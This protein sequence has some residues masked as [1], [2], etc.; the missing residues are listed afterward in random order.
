MYRNILFLKINTDY[1]ASQQKKSILNLALMDRAEKLKSFIDKVSCCYN[2]LIVKKCYK[3]IVG[4]KM[5]I[6]TIQCYEQTYEQSALTLVQFLLF[7]HNKFFDKLL[8]LRQAA[9]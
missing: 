3:R 1:E 7:F 8:A 4:I 9:L 2:N 5:Y 6:A